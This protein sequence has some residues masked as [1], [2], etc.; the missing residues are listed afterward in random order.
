M[1]RTARAQY[2]RSRLNSNVRPHQTNLP[3]IERFERPLS[4]SDARRVRARIARIEAH[5]APKVVAIEALQLLSAGAAVGIGYSLFTHTSLLN[6]TVGALVIAVG[7]L[8]ILQFEKWRS[9]AKSKRQLNR[10]LQS[11]T[12]HVVR[13]RSSAYAEFCELADLG[14]VYAFEVGDNKLFVVRG[15]EYYETEVFPCLDFEL[16]NVA[17]A[18]SVI[19]TFGP[20]AAPVVKY[21]VTAMRDLPPIEDGAV[22]QGTAANAFASLRS[23][24]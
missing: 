24:V 13:V 7:I 8:A 2:R 17:G 11:G 3:V 4:E 21:P 6:S 20:K 1:R 23:A 18:F 19:H 22:V 10:V 14:P 12:A 9:T 16:V 5:V 15:Q